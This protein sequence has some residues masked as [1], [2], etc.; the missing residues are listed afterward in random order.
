M[1]FKIKFAKILIKV[2]KL[3][4]IFAINFQY[5]FEF[6]NK[7]FKIFLSFSILLKLFHLNIVELHAFDI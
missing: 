3:F 2:L 4:Q 7:I 1:N 6:C 5:F